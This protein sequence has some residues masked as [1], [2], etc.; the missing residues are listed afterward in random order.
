MIVEGNPDFVFICKGRKFFGDLIRALGS[1]SDTPKRLRHLE[2]ELDLFIRLAKRQL[3]EM[4]V[5][6]RVIVHFAQVAALRQLGL[7]LGVSWRWLRFRRAAR[8][9][10]PATAA[11]AGE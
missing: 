5:D 10:A 2:V 7:A 3:M 1:D 8:A 9:I 4:N 11:D 6:A